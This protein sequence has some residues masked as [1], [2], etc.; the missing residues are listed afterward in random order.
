M[1]FSFWRR[2]KREQELEEE[3][4]SHLEMAARDRMDR[5]EAPAHAARAARREFGNVGLVREITT[6]NWGWRW[7]DDLTQDLRYGIRTM[8]RSPGFVAVAVV[9]LA[10]GI[11]ANTAIFS[12]MDAFVWAKLPVKDPQ[13]L[14]FIRGIASDGRGFSEFPY[15]EFEY[16]RNHNSSFSGMFA[17]DDSRNNITVD[18]QSEILPDDFVSGN[19]FEV[20]GVNAFLGRTL[21][22]DD[23]QKGRRPVA[24]ISYAYWQKRFAGS[25]EALGKTIYVGQMPFTIVGVTSQRFFGRSVAGRSASVVLPMWVQPQLRLRDHDTFEIMARRKPGVS[26]EEARADLDVAY[27]QALMEEE[28]S[29][30]SPQIQKGASGRRIVLQPALRGE[31]Q[32]TENFGTEMRILATVVGLALLMACVNVA[33]LLVAR[34]WYRQK[35]ISVRVAIGAGRGRLIRQLLTESVLLALLGGALGLLLA[36]WGVGLLLTVLSYGYAPVP[37]D[38]SPNV[39]VL[40]FTA[41]ISALTG[42]LFGLVPAL[43][44]TRVDLNPVLRGAEAHEGTGILHRGLAKSL[45]IA[46]VALSLALL[47]GA[48]LLL[49]SLKQLYAVDAGYDGG[50]ILTMWIFPAMTYHDRAREMNLYR[51]LYDKLNTVPGVQSASLSRLRMVYGRWYRRV[52]VQGEAA[53]SADAPEVYCDPVGPR[54]FETMGIGLLLGREFSVRD[55]ETSQKVAIISESMARKFFPAENPL[56]RRFG[57]DGEKSSGDVEVVGVVKDIKHRI[58]EE[59]RQEAAWIPYTQAPE[60]MYGQ[61]TLLVRATGGS[62]SMAPAIRV[63]VQSVDKGLPLGNVETEAAELDDYLGGWRSMGTLVSFFSGLALL[64]AALGLYG[65][66]T[67]VVQRRTKELGIRLALGAE[68]RRLLWMVLHEALLLVGVGATLGVPAAWAATRL[69]S[70]MLFGVKATDPTTIAIAFLLMSATALLAAYLPAQRAARVDP[71]VALRYE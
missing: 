21:T 47:V 62:A 15:A 10:I 61:M 5:G 63:Q 26:L 23:D 45:V 30:D 69:I 50:K 49:R 68:R 48:G 17:F 6:E 66:M 16:L 71:I 60:D 56:G 12:L 40:A 32:P 58:G 38:L 33:G 35:E 51:E 8:R 7:L 53:Q 43:A 22:P 52:W 64:L 24:V 2:Q 44:G 65:A 27:R 46:Q 36:K 29:P 59:E 28:A 39:R 67:Y 1:T 9:T 31:G 14:V 41:G 3:L 37:F 57:F 55:A 54:F 70:G 42:V 25:D 4:K 34:A 19:Y 20:L 18:G 13:Q 11:G